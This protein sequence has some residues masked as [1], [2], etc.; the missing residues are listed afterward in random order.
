LSASPGVGVSQRDRTIFSL[1]LANLRSVASKQLRLRVAHNLKV[2]DG[3]YW[4]FASLNLEACEKNPK[5]GASAAF[6][7]IP[8]GCLWSGGTGAL[9][10]HNLILKL[11]MKP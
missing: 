1:V 11:S 5:N 2:I 6:L 4:D 8:F 3:L 9:Y 10:N 7:C